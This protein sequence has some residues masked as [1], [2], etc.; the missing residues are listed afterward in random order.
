MLPAVGTPNNVLQMDVDVDLVRRLHPRLRE[1]RGRHLGHPGLVDQRGHLVLDV[2]A[3]NSGTQM[4]ID[5]L[6]NRNPGSTTDDAERWTVPFVDDFTGWQLLEFPF[7]TFIRKEIGNGAP[8]DG[9]GLFEMHGYALGTLGTG[10]PQTFYFDEVSVY[11][12][13]EP[14]ALAV[15]LLA[16]E[17]VHRGGHDRR[18]RRQAQPADGSGRPGPGQHRL[19]HRALQR[20]ARRGLHAR[21]AAR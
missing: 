5:I 9:L 3:P 20:D 8:N 18:R 12:V 17:H 21:P 1:R 16:A 6:D 15:Q 19:R 11:G 13:A 7:R 10:G 4:F 2:T 14:P